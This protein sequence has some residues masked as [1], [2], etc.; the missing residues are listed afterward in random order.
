MSADLNQG[1]AVR[2]SRVT[3]SGGYGSTQPD[4]NNV[5]HPGEILSPGS[6]VGK[7]REFERNYT[8]LAKQLETGQRLSKI[9]TF[10]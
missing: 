7:I 10:R 5:R 9:S 1:L 2:I 3:S 4:G 8:L 6:P